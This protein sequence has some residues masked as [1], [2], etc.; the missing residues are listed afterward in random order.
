MMEILDGL[1]RKAGQLAG[2]LQAACDHIGI[3]MFDPFFENDP[4]WSP[5]SQMMQPDAAL[6]PVSQK[7]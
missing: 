4:H 7:W 1:I 3:N 6:L 5:T 2:I